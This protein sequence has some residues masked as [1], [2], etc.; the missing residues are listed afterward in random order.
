MQLVANA[1][2]CGAL[3]SLHLPG[4][5]LARSR[6]GVWR[7]LLVKYFTD[8]AK[9]VLTIMPCSFFVVPKNAVVVPKTSAH[10]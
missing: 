9:I 2:I 10:S 4:I 7:L 5:C 8:R 3:A 1:V 6:L